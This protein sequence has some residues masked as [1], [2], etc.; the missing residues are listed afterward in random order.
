MRMPKLLLLAMALALPLLLAGCEKSK[1]SMAS[2]LAIAQA[3][4]ASP[5]AHGPNDRFYKVQAK[6]DQGGT[7][8]LYSDLQGV[9]REVMDAIKPM[10]SNPGMPPEALQIYAVADK[11]MDRLG[12]F[13]V[14]D[15]GISMMPDG[16]L[17]RT[18]CYISTPEGRRK[19]IL[20]IL[21]GDPHPM[22]ILDRAPANTL[23]MAAGDFDTVATWGLIR[24]IATDIAGA[25]GPAVI[26]QG[27]MHAKLLTGL[28]LEAI[29]ASLGGEFALLL[30]QDPATQMTIPIPNSPVSLQAPRLVLMIK[31]KDATLYEGLKNLVTLRAGGKPEVVEGKLKCVALSMPPNLIWP[32]DPALA[33]DG[34]FVYISTHQA[35]IR[36][37]AN[38]SGALLRD[39]EEFKRLSAG[40][41]TQV[42]GM[43][44][45]NA[46]LSAQVASTL[47]KIFA[48]LPE[49]GTG[50]LDT[51]QRKMFMSNLNEMKSGAFSVRINETDGVLSIDR[52]KSSGMQIAAAALVAPVGILAAIAVPNFL[53]AQSRSKV[54]RTRGDL[55]TLT[56][57]LETYYLD[58][59]AYPPSSAD[60]AKNLFSKVAPAYPALAKQP[61][62]AGGQLTTPIAYLS[63]YFSDPFAEVKNTPYCY[64]SDG[65]SVYLTWSP[66]PDGKFDITKGNVAQMIDPATHQP[67]AALTELTY[68]PTNGTKSAGDIWRI[69]Q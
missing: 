66:G 68:D 32:V 6:L 21:G 31:V 26:D 8:Y 48:A 49:G 38:P 27:L 60:A 16:D 17:T 42:N 43:A 69:K 20:T 34:E 67:T 39:S 35:F 29:N 12:V 64:Y 19:G 41:P 28:D 10:I 58:N 14:H 1:G 36:Q 52:S 51:M 50:G 30:D 23:F 63:S 5:T 18:K 45:A 37:V 65:K 59:N 44:F 11:V 53:E 56:I 57:A 62:F 2:G 15:L 9:V 61:T 47:G 7:F 3:P 46:R 33:T 22:A 24:Q 40:L 55:R 54:A 13:G 4:P 25:Q